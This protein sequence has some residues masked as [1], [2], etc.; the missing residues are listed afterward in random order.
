MISI[1]FRN[2]PTWGETRPSLARPPCIYLYTNNSM[3]WKIECIFTSAVKAREWGR[4]CG[5]LIKFLSSRGNSSDF[6]NKNIFYLEINI[7]YCEIS[8]SFLNISLY[9]IIIDFK[10]APNMQL[11]QSYSWF[12]DNNDYFIIPLKLVSN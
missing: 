7:I 3:P 12:D 5:F 1:R 4:C 10:R 11:S 9:R 6:K 2:I 8:D